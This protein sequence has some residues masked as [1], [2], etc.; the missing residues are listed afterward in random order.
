MRRGAQTLRFRALL[1]EE[2]AHE[3][4]L[5]LGEMESLMVPEHKSA[6]ASIPRSP[7]RTRYQ[8]VGII[9]SLK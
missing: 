8:A 4:E 3:V 2:E 6:P 7:D 9:E 5:T 1:N